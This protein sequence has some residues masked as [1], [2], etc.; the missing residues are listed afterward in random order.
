MTQ[1]IDELEKR[2]IW[3][4]AKFTFQEFLIKCGAAGKQL[5]IYP[6]KTSWQFEIIR[7]HPLYK[8]SIDIAI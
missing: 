7:I 2:D 6:G 1:A 5:L 4:A 8:E 3:Q